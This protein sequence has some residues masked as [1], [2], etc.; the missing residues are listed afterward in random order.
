MRTDEMENMRQ[1]F[2]IIDSST[3]KQAQISKNQMIVMNNDGLFFLV[4]YDFY[5]YVQPLHEVFPKY[6]VVW[7]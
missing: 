7:K 2:K 5:T 1:K 4:T 6:D 3:S